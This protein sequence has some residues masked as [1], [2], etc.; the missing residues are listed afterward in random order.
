MMKFIFS[1]SKMT[2]KLKFFFTLYFKEEIELESVI[3]F[4]N[5]LNYY[6]LVFLYKFI[7]DQSS[8]SSNQSLFLFVMFIFGQYKR[9][10]IALLFERL[11]Q[12]NQLLV[13]MIFFV[14]IFQ[15]GQSTFVTNFQMI[16]VFN[17]FIFFEITKAFSFTALVSIYQQL[18]QTM[19]VF[20]KFY[21]INLMVTFYP[22]FNFLH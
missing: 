7:S 9:Y 6:Y 13:F 10:F 11:K 19:M 18:Q 3:V 5:F 22:I 1:Y 14:K 21:K 17:D 15:Y 8:S 20:I 4:F 16:F 2:E 12:F